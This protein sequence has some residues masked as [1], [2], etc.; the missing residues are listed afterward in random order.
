M[1]AIV[2]QT[3]FAV[4]NFVLIAFVL[5]KFAGPKVAT[6][7]KERNEANRQALEAAEAAQAQAQAELAEFRTRLANVEQELASIVSTAKTNAAQVAQDIA[8]TTESDAQRLREGAKAEVEREKSLAQQT[9]RVT[10]LRRA[11]EEAEAELKRQMSPDLQHQ[12]VARFIQ[13]VGDGSCR[14]TL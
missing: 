10:M 13:K 1:N 5:Y 6:M 14:I 12:L 4:F 2:L 11:L 8:V 3:F 7:L 9:I